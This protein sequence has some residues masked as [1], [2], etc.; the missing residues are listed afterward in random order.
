MAMHI[1]TNLSY[2]CELHVRLCS[3]IKKAKNNIFIKSIDS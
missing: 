3:D 2:K 1:G